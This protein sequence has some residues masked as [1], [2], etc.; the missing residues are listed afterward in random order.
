M[1]TDYKRYKTTGIYGLK[2]R[3]LYIIPTDDEKCQV[4]NDKA[5]LIIDDIDSRED[6]IWEIE[7]K[8][9]SEKEIEILKV[10]YKKTISELTTLMIDYFE[11]KDKGSKYIYEMASLIRDRKN[12]NKKW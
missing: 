8:F 10:L 4:V 1:K 12:E 9:A 3:N 5:Y 2:Y 7:K 11:K 6:A